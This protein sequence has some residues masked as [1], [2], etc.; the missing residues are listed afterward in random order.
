[1][2]DGLI[3]VFLV[4]SKYKVN[5]DVFMDIETIAKALKEL[6]HPTRLLIYKSVVRA[7][8]QGI[9]VG[10]LQEKLAIP[11]STLSHHISGLVSAELI[12]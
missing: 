8:Y 9:A 2:F 5:W 6:G 4:I 7:G 3:K 11:G 1:V 10:G 12:S